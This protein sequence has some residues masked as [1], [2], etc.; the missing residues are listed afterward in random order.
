MISF[1]LAGMLGRLV[2]VAGNDEKG[3]VVGWI[4]TA[5]E[6]GLALIDRSARAMPDDGGRV[7]LSS[8]VKVAVRMPSGQVWWVDLSST[9]D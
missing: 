3:E 5:D 8:A 1:S 2:R 4:L 7:L 6:Y 9:S